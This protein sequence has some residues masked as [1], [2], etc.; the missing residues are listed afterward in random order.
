MYEPY[1]L[2]RL[3][4]TGVVI[5]LKEGDY[6]YMRNHERGLY[7]P[8]PDNNLVLL[9]QGTKHEVVAYYNLINGGNLNV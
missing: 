7:V 3:P 2:C 4:R 1:Y 6:K 9:A 5:L 8:D